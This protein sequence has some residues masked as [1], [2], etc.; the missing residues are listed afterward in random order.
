MSTSP[1]NI[2]E[3]F[4]VLRNISLA[5]ISNI[6]SEIGTPQYCGPENT[7]QVND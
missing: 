2:S 7:Y 5:G 1:G 4:Q 6:S 3:I